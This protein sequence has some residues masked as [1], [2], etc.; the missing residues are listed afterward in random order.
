MVH[1]IL[2]FPIRL[3]NTWVHLKRNKKMA[4][5]IRRVGKRYFVQTPAYSFPIE[6]HYRIIGFQ[7]YPQFLKRWR[8]QYLGAGRLAKIPCKAEARQEAR[9]I[10]LLRLLEI[11][12]LFPEA[13][14]YK[15]RFCGLTKSYIVYSG[16]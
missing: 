12:S 2:Y 7:W 3:L 6:P 8:L 13:N 14:I 5:E 11:R 15:E 16:F 1:L 10:R 9:R 4:E